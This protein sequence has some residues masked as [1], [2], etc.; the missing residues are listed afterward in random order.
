MRKS[1]VATVAQAEQLLEAYRAGA[2]FFLS[3]PRRTI[4]AEGVRASLQSE[5]SGSLVERVT[6]LLND[7]KRAEDEL[8]VV[9]GAVSFDHTK[10]A[11][12]VVP[13]SVQWAGP[14]QFGSSE[15]VTQPSAV[16]YEMEPVPKPEEFLRGVGQLLKSSP[17]VCSG[18]FLSRC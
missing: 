1:N 2:P 15:P 18:L 17:P 12:L 7:A 14:L 8:A 5:A 6:A 13:M 11:Q 3:S 4:L 9:V 10:P 16:T